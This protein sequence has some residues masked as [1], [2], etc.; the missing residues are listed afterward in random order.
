LPINTVRCQRTDQAK[1]I[2]GCDG[3][4]AV[5]LRALLILH[6]V[7]WNQSF[8]DGLFEDLTGMRFFVGIAWLLLPQ[9]Q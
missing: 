2:A 8:H 1:L 3:H 4:P 9:S 7:H 5:Y 6:L